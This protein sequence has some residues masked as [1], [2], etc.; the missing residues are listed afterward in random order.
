MLF[1]DTYATPLI[2]SIKLS[3]GDTTAAEAAP[4]RKLDPAEILAS[5]FTDKPVREPFDDRKVMMK[6]RQVLTVED[7]AGL[8][9]DPMIGDIY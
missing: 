3:K 1:Y 6:L 7:F 8:F 9:K 4:K 2:Q 5:L